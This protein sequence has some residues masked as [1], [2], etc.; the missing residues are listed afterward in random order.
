MLLVALVARR[1]LISE[2]SKSIRGGKIQ[3]DRDDFL[4]NIFPRRRAKRRRGSSRFEI[5]EERDSFL[6]NPPSVSSCPL[7]F[8][9]R[10]IKGHKKSINQI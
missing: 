8:L 1:I 6:A 4:S 9:H 10:Q 7:I 2:E 5:N 3:N